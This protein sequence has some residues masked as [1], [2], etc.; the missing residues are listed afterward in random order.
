MALPPSSLFI[1]STMR[2][3]YTGLVFLSLFHLEGSDKIFFT[4]APHWSYPLLDKM[5]AGADFQTF[6][7]GGKMS[8]RL[9]FAS[10]S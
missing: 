4:C 8:E 2:A 1:S 3:V 10:Q 6:Q 5:R 7:N 9:G